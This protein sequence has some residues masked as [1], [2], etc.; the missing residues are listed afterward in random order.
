MANID[1][2][3]FTNS[4][5]NE[6][7]SAWDLLS[8]VLAGQDTIKA[9]REKY[10]PQEMA[11][12]R[13]D[14]EGRLKR[15]L[16]FEDYRDCVVNLT[17]M[18]FRKS[19][20]LGDDVPEPIKQ[21]AENIDNAGT[22]VD[23]FLQRLFED[24]FY[25]HS[26][27]VVDLPTKS[28]NVQTAADEL[29]A[30][31]YWVLRQAK[32][33]LN[34]RTALVN[35][36]TI[37]TQITFKECTVEANGAFG[38]KKVTRYRVY[39]LDE[40]GNAEWQLWEEKTDA[41]ENKIEVVFLEKGSI[42]TKKGRPLK[43]LPIAV[44]Y[45]EHEGFLHSR[46]PL[47]GIADIN[48][49]YFQKY[50]DLTNIEH[51]TC[52]VT[53]AL[54]GVDDQSGNKTIGG[55]CIIYLPTGADAKFLEINGDSIPALERDLEMLQKRLVAKG[56]DFVEEKNRVPPTAT[57]V[58]L[59]YTQRTSKLAKMVRSII[60]CTEEAFDITAEMEGLD[61][62]G[63]ITLGVDEN[64]LTLTPD[65]LDKYSL[66]NERGQL[67]LPTLWA[68]MERADLLPEDFDAKAEQ[69]V[70]DAAAIKQMELNAKQF[71]TGYESTP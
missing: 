41:A 30:R 36:K 66:M 21:L 61:Q 54:I 52:A 6:M 32:D 47:K 23:V 50:S 58:V 39:R 20:K 7:C 63:S 42:L 59:A 1:T 48:L 29:G 8:D 14:Y 3:D 62:G 24:G 15:S 33:A 2:P 53:L 37:I 26:F 49:S 45:G 67:S 57:E 70:L 35:G 43:R 16:F 17:G 71:D 27:V 34:W 46:P 69:V 11:E 10:L 18:V 38:E 5:Y 12:L 55:N 68:M 9:A 51:H 31:S 25:G 28:E 64:S 60:D 22:H 40:I 56:L 44:H 19:P 13:E 4:G 65:E